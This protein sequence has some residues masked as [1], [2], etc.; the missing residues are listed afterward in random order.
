MSSIEQAPTIAT[1]GAIVAARPAA[2]SVLEGLGLDYCC[3]G[4]RTLAEACAERGL[5][6]VTVL[7]VL[8]SIDADGGGGGGAHDVAAASIE[9]LCDHIVE[10]HHRPLHPKLERIAELLGK[11]VRA[12]GPHDPSVVRLR[13]RF[14]EARAELVEHM[15]VEERE[16]FPACRE[17]GRPGGTVDRD[18]IGHLE[19]DHGATGA[20]LADLRALAGDYRPERAHCN[21]HRVLLHE[22]AALELELHRHIHEENNVLFPKVRDRL[23]AAA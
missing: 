16:L 3:G 21:T 15:R 13:E 12:H 4:G 23:A 11:V 1:L 2:A 19:D 14:E 17:L 6:P 7:A 20:A 5:D 18:L 10:E 8:D 22:L 9:E